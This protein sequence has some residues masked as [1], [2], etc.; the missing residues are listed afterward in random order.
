[1]KKRSFCSLII[2]LSFLSLYSCKNNISQKTIKLKSNAVQTNKDSFQE[3]QPMAISIEGMICAVGCAA[4]IEKTLNKTEGIKEA[5]VDF[6]TKK[7]TLIFNP[8]V[9]TANEVAQIVQNTGEA[10]SVKDFELLD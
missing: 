6:E 2:G 9:L 10:Y 7:A 3:A 1:M 4:L 5:K 8:K